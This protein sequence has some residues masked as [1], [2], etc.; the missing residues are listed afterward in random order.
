MD[1]YDWVFIE[2]EGILMEGGFDGV[3]YQDLRKDLP[4][5]HPAVGRISP[6]K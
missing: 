2:F 5:V 1:E 4:E 3:E 6:P